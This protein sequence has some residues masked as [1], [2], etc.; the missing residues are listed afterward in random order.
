MTEAITETS[1]A[2]ATSEVPLESPAQAVTEPDVAGTPVQYAPTGD[3]AI[4]LGLEFVGNLGIG[5][6]NPAILSAEGGDFG[7]ID[8]L[9]ADMGAKAQGYEKVLKVFEAAYTRQ[10][11]S[12]KAANEAH[13]ETLFAAVGGK[14]AW[15]G[16]KEWAALEAS[17]EEVASINA[18]LGLGGLASILVVKGLAAARGGAPSGP[19]KVLSPQ[20]TAKVADTGPLSMPEY[21]KQVQALSKE[22][23]P[24]M[25]KSP[26]YRSLQ[27]RLRK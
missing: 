5:R 13:Q 14:E 24:A 18:A 10:A 27:L 23:G 4:D 25:D 2:V 15:E 20:A 21:L 1:A 6:D 19:T 7:P 9:L 16:I 17:P 12:T 8:K 11:S 3:P 26:Q 22:L